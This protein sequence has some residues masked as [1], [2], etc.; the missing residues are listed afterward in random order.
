MVV[1]V[2]VPAVA[3]VAAVTAEPPAVAAAAVGTEAVAA[4]VAIVE[5]V[6]V[7]LE[8]LA[9]TVTVEVLARA[10]LAATVARAR[11]AAA[12]A[13]VSG[14]RMALQW[15]AKPAAVTVDMMV[16]KSV[17]VERMEVEKV[18]LA[19]VEAGMTAVKVIGLLRQAV[20]EAPA[21]LEA[22]GAVMAVALGGEVVL[23]NLMGSM[24]HRWRAGPGHCSTEPRGMPIPKRE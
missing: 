19:S 4:R 16:A 13:R 10:R 14:E 2:A 1:M 9:V 21:L 20:L 7:S 24:Q 18:A 5:R 8:A 17:A 3:A 11:L 23:R 15:V 6:A 12:V 22:E